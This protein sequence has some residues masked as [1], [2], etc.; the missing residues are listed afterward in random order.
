MDGLS[1]AARVEQSA[2][3]KVYLRVVPICFLLYILCYIDRINISFAALTMNQDIGLS[4]HVYG[5]GAGL[6]WWSYCLLE[7]PSNYLLQKF[8]ARLW[9]GRIMITWGLVATA[10][11]LIQ[12]P[13][14]F[15]AL[16]LLLGAAESGLYPGLL[17]YIYRFFPQ[18]HRS[19]V[20]GWFMLAMTMAT[21]IGS[22]LSTA[23]LQLDGLAG[24][25]GWQWIFVG[26]GFPTVIIGV[27]VV[28][29]LTERPREAGWLTPE[30]R[31]WLEAELAK[32]A[33]EI[34]RA[35]A[36]TFLTAMA[37]PRVWALTALFTFICMAGS[38]LEMFIPQILK[39]AGASITQAG[40]LTSI[41]F[42]VGTL[43]MIVS[44]HIADHGNYRVGVLFTTIALGAV[45]LGLGAMVHNSVWLLV[46]AASMAAA[47][48]YAMRPP[49]WPLPSAFLTGPVLVITVPAINSIG[50]I[51][52][53]AGPVVVGYARDATGNFEAGMYVLA[54]AALVSAL[55][56]LGCWLWM[57]GLRQQPALHPAE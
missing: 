14:S 16:R 15:Y 44:G 35:H 12:G 43:A 18:R 46:V 1:A 4:A 11:A 51:G 13:I 41:P 5:M 50:N 30:E 10:C 29:C 56:S 19:R 55:V 27:W 20:V 52:S 32:E 7:V 38:G 6:M 53:W 24:L 39:A 26:E 21:V 28:F 17:V 47:G 57:P 3:R 42:I 49:F 54:A 33:H 48:I 8:G 9:L 25:R 37:D 31:A 34:E 23:L 2:L 45:G 40:L 22:P 36:H